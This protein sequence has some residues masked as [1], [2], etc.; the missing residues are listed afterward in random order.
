MK[1][2]SL[3][4]LADFIT[5]PPAR[6][7]STL[8]QYKYPAEHDARA[9]ILYYREARDRIAA[10]N[11][12]RQQCSWLLTEAHALDA[13]AAL[14]AGATKT[15]L[16]HNATALRAYAKHF[17]PRPFEV[18][19]DLTLKLSYGDVVVTVHPDLHAVER[20]KEKIIKVEFALHRPSDQM[21][22][23][24]C[25]AMFEAAQQAKMGLTSSRVLYL[26]LRRGTQHKGARMGARVRAEIEAACSNISAIWDKL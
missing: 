23:I 25:Q 16:S 5:A 21:V 15:R 18:I 12:G 10:Y 3:K 22:K 19:D 20:A 7:R 6:Q 14:S 1:K 26:D 8:K 9:R 13:L 24:I 17:G 11:R 2:L 4:G